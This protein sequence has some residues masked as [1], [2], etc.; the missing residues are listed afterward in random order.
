VNEILGHANVEAGGLGAGV[1]GD[2]DG[3]AGWD[4][5]QARLVAEALAVAPKEIGG[6]WRMGIWGGSGR[7]IRL[8]WRARRGRGSRGWSEERAGIAAIRAEDLPWRARMRTG[9]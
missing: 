5:G 1:V 4:G 3:L 8:L 6:G 9:F 7:R 2:V